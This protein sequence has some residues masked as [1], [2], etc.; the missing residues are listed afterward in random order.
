MITSTLALALFALPVALGA[1]YNVQVGAGGKLVYDPEY[2]S[3]QPGDVINFIFNP[4]NHTVTQS[5]FNTPCVALDG[6]AKTGFVPVDAGTTDLPIRQFIV[7]A[8]N[9]PL[10]FY[11]GQT[12]HCGQ[13]M[14]FA[15]NP[16]ADPSP[17]SF[18]AFKALAQGGTPSSSS[19]P[20]PSSS[21]YVTP[22]APHWV[23]ATAT[24]TYGGSVYT[25]TYTSY[26]GTPPP[27]PAPVPVDHKIIVGNN[28]VLNY[29]PANISASI[30][31]TVTFEFHPKNHTVTQSSFLNPCQALELTSGTPGFKSGFQPV[32]ADAT[33]FPTFQITINDT[34]PI[35]GYCGQTG[36]CA[37]GMV[38]AIN[39][40]ES[41]PNNFAAFLEL[42]KRSGSASA[43]GTAPS[44]TTASTAASSTA[45]S[46]AIG[47]ARGSGAG[48]T[49]GLALSA[50]LALWV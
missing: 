20:P 37:Q 28:G 21:D 27:T 11:C 36:H 9:A 14:V 41:G 46:A 38:F 3:A 45:S 4:K 50:M 2:V 1:E 44:G 49:L 47:F 25:T 31:D 26:D 40:V 48:M 6:G 18:S 24:V 43:S 16:P 17:N 34:A 23:S 7:P 15:I 33:E 5:S 8:G 35:W 30:G 42:A 22:P 32:A 29:D 13:G 39:A 12:G 10:W 19:S